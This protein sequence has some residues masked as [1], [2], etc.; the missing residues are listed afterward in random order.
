[1]TRSD[2]G[3]ARP[4]LGA[5]APSSPRATGVAYARGAVGGLLVAM[6]LLLTMEMWWG[7]FLIPAGRLALLVAFNYVV[8]YILQHYSGLHPRKTHASQARAAAAAYGI[9]VLVSLATLAAVNVVHGD[10]GARELVGKLVLEAVPVSIGASVSMSQFGA[11]SDVAERRKERET[12]WGAMAMALAGAVF[13]GFSVAA[14][15][16]AMMVGLRISAAHGVILVVASL[17]LAHLVVF[18]VEF[19]RRHERSRR[20][21][22]LLL[23]EGV[24]AY[25]VA[26]FVAAYLL[27]TFGRIGPDV[28]LAAARDMIVG[29]GLAT[30][31]GAAAGELLI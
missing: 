1:M 23:K 13:F 28:G 8:L 14:T 29:L 9:G 6:P 17:L 26:L 15:E 4:A 18:A 30:S 16:E 27:W 10:L 19:R 31:L 7:G 2:G 22:A 20:W 11:E 24:G 12:F 5:G 21:W 25:A 3:D